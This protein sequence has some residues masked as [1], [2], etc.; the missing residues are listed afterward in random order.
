MR[1]MGDVGPEAFVICD[2]DRT[3]GTGSL[4][5]CPAPKSGAEENRH[6]LANPRPSTDGFPGLTPGATI[7]RA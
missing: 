5:R 6:L 4:D 7:C 3:R 2:S 1:D